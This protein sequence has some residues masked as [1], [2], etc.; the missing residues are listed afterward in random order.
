M[1]RPRTAAWLA[2]A[3]A[4]VAAPAMA[5]E[6]RPG[7][8][9]DGESAREWRGV[10]RVNVGGLRTR[11]LCTGTLIA[12]D[13]VL[14]AAHCIVNQRTGIPQRPRSIYF[15]AGWL[16]GE[17]SGHSVAAAVSVHPFY[18]PD[19]GSN[20]GLLISDVA[21]IRLRERLPPEVAQPFEVAAPPRPGSPIVVVSYR[22]DRPHALTYQ[23][24]C[25]FDDQ[26]GPVVVLGCSVATGASGAPVLAEIDGEMRV[27]ASLVAMAPDER[28]I[29]IQAKGVVESLLKSL[30][31]TRAP[32]ASH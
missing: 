10:G 3:A 15:V 26:Q 27:V 21:L 31:K 11:G 13:V 23:D 24:D 17:M 32:A 12:P 20:P 6:E 2:L 29:A 8:L 16:K 14:T 30:D 5:A 1:P 9:L 28:A 4:L 18:K 25:T 22:R 19:D 7:K